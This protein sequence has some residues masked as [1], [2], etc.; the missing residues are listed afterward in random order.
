M[1]HYRPDPLPARLGRPPRRRAR[2]PWRSLPALAA[3]CDRRRD[4]VRQPRASIAAVSLWPQS[5]LLGPNLSRLPG[6]G[7]PRRG[8]AHLRRRPGPR[9]HAA[10]ARP[11]RR[12]PA[13]APPSSA[14]AGG[15][16]PTPDLAAE[17]VRRGH[18]VENHTWSHPNAFACYRPGAQRREIDRAQEAIERATGRLPRWFRAPAGFRNLFLERELWSRPGSTLASWTRRG[19]DTV[20][21]SPEAVAGRLLRGLAAGDVLLL[22]DG[23]R[24]AGGGARS[25]W[26]V[27][28]AAAGRDRRPRACVR[29]LSR[30]EKPA[31]YASCSTACAPRAAPRDARPRR[32]G[33]ASSSAAARSTASTSPS[34]W[35]PPGC[36]G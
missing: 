16:P 27:L 4:A 36:C 15:S 11:A 32:S 6:R 1:S 9:G 34:A 10:G 12:A 24:P 33:W 2:W 26:S 29:F 14:S 28:P 23:T 25:S 30:N 8:G 13:P 5:R 3:A 31:D 7:P 21:R 35:S 22:H 18:R 17:I 19:Y 20:A